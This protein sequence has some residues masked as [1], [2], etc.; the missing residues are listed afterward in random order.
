MSHSTS[1]S[2]KF[3]LPYVFNGSLRDA[4]A[5]KLQSPYRLTTVRQHRSRAEALLQPAVEN[6]MKF[7]GGADQGSEDT[8]TFLLES[9][10]LYD[11]LQSASAATE[12]LGDYN[13]E[14]KDDYVEVGKDAAQALERGQ[15]DME[16]SF[17]IAKQPWLLPKLGIFN[18]SKRFLDP[19][20]QF[21]QT[22]YEAN[23]GLAALEKDKQRIN[24]ILAVLWRWQTI[25]L[26][27]EKGQPGRAFSDNPRWKRPI[28]WIQDRVLP[29][30]H[31]WARDS[32]RTCSRKEL[33]EDKWV[34]ERMKKLMASEEDGE[35]G[36]E[37][38]SRERD[39]D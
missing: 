14:L 26:K 31:P 25:L 24:L 19:L 33:V 5:P 13:S 15:H 38:Q 9:G 8:E 28:H 12:V 36:I 23:I 3:P 34:K 20:E 16:D 11:Q 27:F 7:A 39:R 35:Q 30:H 18:A 10:I 32:S 37:I 1:A 21:R 2:N 22:L 29:S 6:L 4:I 17:E